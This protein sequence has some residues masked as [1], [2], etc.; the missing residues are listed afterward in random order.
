MNISR[1]AFEVT[2][3]SLYGAE[4]VDVPAGWTILAFRPPQ[5]GDYWLSSTGDGKIF[6][7]TATGPR[8]I[9]KK[10]PADVIRYKFD[11]CDD[12]I[13]KGE[14]FITSTGERFISDHSYKLA[15]LFDIYSPTKE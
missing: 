3:N 11:R 15:G 10:A 7:D 6:K 14:M 1:L 4:D 9:L 8:L 5:H 12:W 13:N 2:A